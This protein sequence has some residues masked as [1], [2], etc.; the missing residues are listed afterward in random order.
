M[1]GA[2]FGALGNPEVYGEAGIDPYHEDDRPSRG[3]LKPD[4]PFK[5]E[6]GVARTIDRYKMIQEGTCKQ[7]KRKQQRCIDRIDGWVN[8]GMLTKEDLI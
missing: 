1:M 3:S 4:I 7:N 2:M 5:H 6:E 8:S